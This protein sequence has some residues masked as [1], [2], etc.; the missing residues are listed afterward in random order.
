[1]IRG[2]R[3]GRRLGFPTANLDVRPDRVVPA[4]GVYAT[5]TYLGAE[6]FPSVTNVGVRPSFDHGVRSVEAHLIDFDRD[7]YGRDLVI[8]FVVRLRPEL[9]FPDVQDL[10]AQ[11]GRDV[12]QAR[13]ILDSTPSQNTGAA[14]SESVTHR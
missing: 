11:V 10:I 8:A 4:N 13:Q 2:A 1:M 12:E 14:P 5:Y 9:R 6:R 3:R 7:L